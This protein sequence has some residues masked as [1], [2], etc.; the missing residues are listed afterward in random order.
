MSSSEISSGRALAIAD[1]RTA[2]GAALAR[3]RGARSRPRPVVEAG[4]DH[5][6]AHLVGHALVDHGA[7][8]DV[9]VR[10]GRVLD[11]LGG[12]VDLEQAEVLAAR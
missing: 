7:E 10:V 8:D 9:G 2:V 11:D 6:D 1:A 12:V 5:G 3:A 4:A